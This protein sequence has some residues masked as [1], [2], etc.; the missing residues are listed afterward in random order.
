MPDRG[1]ATRDA[2]RLTLLLPYFM[3]ACIYSINQ[4]ILGHRGKTSSTISLSAIASKNSIRLDYLH[5]FQVL[6]RLSIFQDGL[7][8]ISIKFEREYD[9]LRFFK[10]I[11]LKLVKL[12]HFS[13]T[14]IFIPIVK[15]Y[16]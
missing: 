1:L 9:Y 10:S 5:S 15:G 16:H 7:I 2:N 4:L 13:Q 14:Q 6:S 12:F 8:I 11:G 3:N